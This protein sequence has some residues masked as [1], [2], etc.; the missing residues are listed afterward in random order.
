[1]KKNTHLSVQVFKTTKQNKFTKIK[2]A[3][4]CETISFFLSKKQEAISVKFAQN[5]GHKK[6]LHFMEFFWNTLKRVG[7]KVVGKKLQKKSENNK[8]SNKSTGRFYLNT[9]LDLIMFS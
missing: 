7:K 3:V 4:F 5:K 9:I 2:Q 6:I 1:M 8:I